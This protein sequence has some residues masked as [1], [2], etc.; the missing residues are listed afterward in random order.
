MECSYCFS[1]SRLFKN[2]L[3]IYQETSWEDLSTRELKWLFFML[4]IVR[5]IGKFTHSAKA[6][7]VIMSV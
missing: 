4:L 6:E 7:I 1:L 5:G 2:V 3:Q